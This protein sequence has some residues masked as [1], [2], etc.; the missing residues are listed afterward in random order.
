V[1][2]IVEF[3]LIPELVGR[4]PVITG[5]SQLSEDDLVRILVEPKN[6]LIKQYQRFFEM[7]NAQLEVTEE[8]LHEIARIALQRNT[9]ARGLRSVVEQIMFDI[10]FE[11][12]EIGA[13][14]RFVLTPEV[15]R[16]EKKMVALD[17]SAAA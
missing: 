3:G 5:L 8:A 11:L 16:G 1:D 2:D 17:D 7:E 14:K 4:L 9:G 10:L 13:G 6:A 15:V 12:P